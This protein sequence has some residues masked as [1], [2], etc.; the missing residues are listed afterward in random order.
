MEFRDNPWFV[1]TNVKGGGGYK[2]YICPSALKKGGLYLPI[3]LT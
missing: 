1:L 2:I 3:T